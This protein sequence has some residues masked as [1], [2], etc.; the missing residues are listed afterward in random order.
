VAAP[1]NTVGLSGVAALILAGSL[2]LLIHKRREKR[3]AVELAR[4]KKAERI[5]QLLEP[6][7]ASRFRREPIRLPDGEKQADRI[8][9]DGPR[10]GT[11]VF[12]TD[13]APN[14]QRAPGATRESG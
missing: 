5:A 1:S 7:P 9:A 4:R 8:T 3:T 11:P 12:R 2:T 6:I 13:S 14:F 10:F